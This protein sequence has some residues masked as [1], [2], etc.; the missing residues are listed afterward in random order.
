MSAR[1]RREAIERLEPSRAAD[2][3][4]LRDAFVLDPDAEART[5]AVL[6]LDAQ[7]ARQLT[8]YLRDATMD[9]SV[10][11]REAAFVVLARAR[12]AGALPFAL[13]AVQSDRAWRVRRAA[14]LMAGHFGD[15]PGRAVLACAT[16]DPFWRVRVA[17]RRVAARLDVLVVVGATAR[18]DRPLLEMPPWH[19]EDPAVVAARLARAGSEPGVEALLPYLAH[20]HEPLRRLAEARLAAVADVALLV[21]AAAWLEDDRTPYA[22]AATERLLA[23]TAERASLAAREIIGRAT[24]GPGVRAWAIRHAVRAP[25]WEVLVEGA[26]S[27]DAR[28]ARASLEKAVETAPSRSE[29]LRLL[30]ERV[31]DDDPATCALAALKLASQGRAGRDLLLA[32]RVTALPTPALALLV[33]VAEEAGDLG[34]LQALS[35]SEHALVRGRALGALARARELPDAA[36]SHAEH[37]EDPWIRAAVLTEARAPAVLA[38]DPDVEVRR[39]AARLVSLPAPEPAASWALSAHAEPDPWLRLRALELLPA[40]ASRAVLGF[41]GDGHPAVRRAAVEAVE[42]RNLDAELRVLALDPNEPS[43]TRRLALTFLSRTMDQAAREALEPILAALGAEDGV[44]EHVRN[45]LSA[46]DRQPPEAHDVAPVRPVPVAA[47]PQRPVPHRR[48]LGRTGLSITPFGLSGARTLEASDF[49]MARERGVNLF[50]WEPPHRELTRFLRTRRD[51]DR[52]VVTGTYHADA[53][54]IERD[55]ARARAALRTERIEVLLAFWTRSMARLDEVQP[56]LTRLRDSGAVGAIGISTH[57]RALAVAAAERGFD[58]VMIRHSAAHRGA[59]SA[60]FPACAALDVGVLTFT[61]LCYGRML[62]RTR[63]PLSSPATAV[64]CYRYSLAQPGVHGC[65]AAPR[66]HRELVED[67]AVVDD[68]TIG[69]DRQGE[70]RVHG[71]EVYAE[72]KA[73]AAETWSAAAPPASPAEITTA[74]EEAVTSDPDGPRG[75]SE[76]LSHARPS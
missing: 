15:Q 68:P 28:L 29:L 51:P 72:A 20:P 45:L 41:L 69:E 44:R 70:L 61:N 62:H 48:R 66:R 42:A 71:N 38:Q 74:L 50:F 18:T 7:A 24:D 59:E 47:E 34:R 11:V 65:I 13:R 14:A 6:R 12:D 52:V 10:R 26:A 60:V 17:A 36:R 27:P 30:A 9:A 19:D 63:A 32:A 37:D 57:D 53:P 35:A 2:R 49:S 31:G 64:D 21:R 5:L 73:W 76:V 56:I 25:A 58:V 23:K 1:G 39:A 40:T 16:S 75:M 54:S 67:L 46:I 4:A 3:F 55:L 22:P 43:A 33:D 8:P